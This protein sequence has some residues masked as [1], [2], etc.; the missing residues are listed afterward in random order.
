[1]SNTWLWWW[2]Q[3]RW[4]SRPKGHKP[5]LPIQKK[6]KVTH[7]YVGVDLAALCTEATFQCIRENMDAIDWK[8]DSI[9]AEILNSMAVL[10]EHFQIALGTSNPSALRE[11]VRIS[12]LYEIIPSYSF[13]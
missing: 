9:D 10:N 3:A 13:K 7:G 4:I 12:I 8:D 11:T 2:V 6:K 5:W 1:M